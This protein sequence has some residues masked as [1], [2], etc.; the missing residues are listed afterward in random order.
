MPKKYDFAVAL[1]QGA[2][3]SVVYFSLASMEMGSRFGVMRFL[4]SAQD[5]ERYERGMANYLRFAGGWGAL[6]T[7]VAAVQGGAKAAGAAA[8]VNGGMI[9][10]VANRYAKAINQM[11]EERGLPAA[12]IP[13][14]IPQ[15]VRIVN[16]E[17]HTIRP[18]W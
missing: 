17:G 2:L 10:F 3:S 16:P 1:A 6:S 18:R 12:R 15:A 8:V 4:E 14:F 7:G 5:V 11:T 9:L 13:T